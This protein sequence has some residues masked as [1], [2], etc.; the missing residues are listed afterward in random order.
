[1]NSKQ[2]TGHVSSVAAFIFLGRSLNQFFDSGI[3]ISG[4]YDDEN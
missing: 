1:M 3:F 4:T 2:L